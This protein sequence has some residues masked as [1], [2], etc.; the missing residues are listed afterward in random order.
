MNRRRVFCAKPVAF[1]AALA[2]LNVA[3]SRAHADEGLWTFDN[4]PAAKVKAA[5]A[6]ISKEIF[7]FPCGRR[8]HFMDP[9]GNELAVWSE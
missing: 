4:F 6:A 8:F 3:A 1:A 9:S 7:S 5:G 2:A